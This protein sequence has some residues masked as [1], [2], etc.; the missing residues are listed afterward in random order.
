M[1]LVPGY[2]G[3]AG[4]RPLPGAASAGCPPVAV[5]TAARVST[6]PWEAVVFFESHPDVTPRVRA[7]T[8]TNNAILVMGVLEVSRVER[9]R[10]G[11]ADPGR[12]AGRGQSSL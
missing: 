6:P 7:R 3:G 1:D 12:Q 11:K 2:F 5:P 8:P 10:R 9:A 4:K